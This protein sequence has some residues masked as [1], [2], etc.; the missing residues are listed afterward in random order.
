MFT[1]YKYSIP[2][3]DEFTLDLPDG[4]RIL[5]VQTQHD[6]PQLWAVVDP[7]AQ[8]ITRRFAIR[9]TGHPVDE[10]LADIGMSSTYRGTFQLRNGSLVFHL[11]ERV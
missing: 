3:E 2:I 10:A 6:A 11:F 9:G 5:C 1:I 4:A 8:R 7:E